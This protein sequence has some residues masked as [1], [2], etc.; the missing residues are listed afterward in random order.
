M[1]EDPRMILD[2]LRGFDTATVCNA[3]ERLK[4]RDRTDGFMGFDIRCLFSDLGPMAGYAVTATVRSAVPGPPGSR[5]GFAG[6]FTALEES[7]NPAVLV[8]KDV[9]P[10]RRRSCHFGEMM[11]TACKRLGAIGLVTDGGV[12]DL[13]TVRELGFHY[14]SPG[15]TPAHGNYEI[16]EA[17]LTIKV[18]G[19]VVQ[20]GDLIH[21]DENGVGVFPAS[22]TGELLEAARAVR[23]HETQ[24][25]AAIADPNR[26]PKSFWE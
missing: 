9:G 21:A 14:F 13:T 11:A 10:D 22:R 7:P 1:T 26:D 23:H 25:M 4:I 16:V 8:F 15:A 20:P 2:Q 5:S 19:T 24:R 6:L 18:G 3:V 17:G 12:R